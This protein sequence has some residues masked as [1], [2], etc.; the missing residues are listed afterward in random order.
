MMT[1]AM[2]D[3]FLQD[4]MGQNELCHRH[5]NTPSN[6]KQNMGEHIKKQLVSCQNQ[7]CHRQNKACEILMMKGAMSDTINKISWAEMNCFIGTKI[8]LQM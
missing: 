8:C 2:S 1:G 3:N 7:L 6:K 5:Q 4:I